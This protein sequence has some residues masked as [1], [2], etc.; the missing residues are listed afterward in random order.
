MF[1]I[2]RSPAKSKKKSF[3]FFS[4]SFSCCQ[5]LVLPKLMLRYSWW[6]KSLG[7]IFIA[8]NFPRSIFDPLYCTGTQCVVDKVLIEHSLHSVLICDIHT[9]RH[10]ICDTLHVTPA[11]WHLTCDT[12]HMIPDT[13]HDIWHVTRCGGV[14]ILSKLQVPSS[15]GLGVMMFCRF[16]GKGSV[17]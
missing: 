1:E 3:F 8:P 14:N 7:V 12:W 10:L 15:C 6:R 11:S 16:G 13:S 4:G 2:L 9:V 17:S 5:S